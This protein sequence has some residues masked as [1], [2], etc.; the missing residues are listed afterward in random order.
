MVKFTVNPLLFVV[1]M[2]SDYHISCGGIKTIFLEVGGAE[3]GEQLKGLTVEM[4]GDVHGD[5]LGGLD[6]IVSL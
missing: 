3:F 2:I 6:L 1:K 5:L 4:I